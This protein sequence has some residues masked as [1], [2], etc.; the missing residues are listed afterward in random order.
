MKK[1]KLLVIVLNSSYGGTEKHVLDIVRHIDN[2]LF[3]IS[4]V[5]PSDSEIGTK[6]KS[7]S[8]IEVIQINR[9]LSSIYK[10]NQIIKVFEPD[11][12]H[13]HSPRATFLGSIASYFVINKKYKIISTA[14]GWIPDRLKLR[15]LYQFLYVNIIKFNDKIFAV[16]NKVKEQIISTGVDDE[17]IV[18]IYNGISIPNEKEVTINT[19]C[20]RKFVFLGRFIEE[21][22][23][24]YLIEAIKKLNDKYQGEFCVDMYGDGPL[25][26]E[27]TYLVNKN[28]LNNVT[29]KGFVDPK[30]VFEILKEY[31]SFLMPS[32]QEG[33]PYTLIEA[34][35]AGLI[36]I[37]SEVGG[38][39]EAI[40]DGVNGYLVKTKNSIDLASKMEYV[41]NL[42][43][44]EFVQ[45]K[46]NSLD[47]S[48]KYSIKNMIES[49]EKHYFEVLSLDSKH[50]KSR[51]KSM[52]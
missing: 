5:V 48:K 34:F 20:T 6:L 15:H 26:D 2:T 41:I 17:S 31:D 38:I 35:S 3:E 22:G 25:V 14:H 39:P 40:N 50:S 21:K 1:I 24:I 18:V 28:K 10:I 52:M 51:R 45:L 8:G 23:L 46:Q 19:K 9:D 33:F 43:I 13:L 42:T 47:S 30:N 37:A 36:V 11:I 44:D 32:I 49:I 7:I 27:I 29:I 12:V 16:S 4:T